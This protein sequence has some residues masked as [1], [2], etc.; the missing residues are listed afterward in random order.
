MVTAR[1]LQEPAFTTPHSVDV[2][3]SQRIKVASFRSTPDIFR[4][5]P[6][7]MVQKPPMAGVA[8]PARFHRLSQPFHD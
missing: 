1:R 2:I 8:L 4:E 3:D 7:A 5:V 6:G